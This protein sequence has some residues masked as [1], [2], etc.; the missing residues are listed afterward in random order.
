MN[1]GT[2][3]LLVEDEPAHVEAVRRAFLAFDRRAEIRVAGTLREY[4]EAVALDSPRIVIL[5]LGLPD[6]DISEA[7][8]ELRKSRPFP[9]LVVT[10]NGDESA[11]V[12]T[13]KAGALDYIV[14]STQTFIEMPHSIERA[15]REWD[16]LQA[17][18]SAEIALAKSEEKY[19]NLVESV[20]DFIYAIDA[21][22]A[23]SYVSPVVRTILGYEP[24]ELVGRP[25][26][27]FVV[28]ADQPE[29]AEKFLALR[30]G[31]LKYSE[32][33]VTAKQGEIRWV[34]SQTNPIFEGGAFAGA[35]GVI[36]DITESKRTADKL[37]DT[38]SDLCDALGGII[39]VL[40]VTS[41]KRDPYTAGHQRRVADLAQAIGRDMG[42]APDRVEG[43]RM[44]GIIHDIGKISVPSE[45]LSKPTRLTEI[46]YEIIKSHPQ[47]G[48]DILSDIA[49]SWPLAEMVFQHHERM[50]GSGYPQGLKGDDILLEARILAVS[51]VVEAM[52]SH[53][54]YRPALGIAA[55]L[56]E[57]EKNRGI[58]YDPDAVAH[59]LTLFR[60]KGFAFK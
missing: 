19:R 35:R 41:E 16:L 30:A 24:E 48:H 3:I 34:R 39:R 52:A 4:R 57:L 36:V 5:D 32:Y 40:S 38:L 47:V 43:V 60:E 17:G 7:V 11:A 15:L 46:E 33:R 26:I 29:I 37:R 49:F 1:R 14:K 28:K 12:A 51:D 18:R 2:Y 31:D 27:E 23:F 44:G 45:I 20:S 21:G 54:P 42:L 56:E 13:I 58:L 8:I 25:F 59:C 6:G 22:G 50:N 10:G 55:A 9:I 53:R